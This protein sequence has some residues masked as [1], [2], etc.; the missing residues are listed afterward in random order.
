MKILSACYD[1]YAN[2]AYA[3]CEALKSVGVDCTGAKLIKH[4]FGYAEELPVVGLD[5]MTELIRAADLVQIMHSDITVLKI[6]KQLNKKSVVYHT[7][8]IYRSRQDYMKQLF[9]PFVLMSF[10]DQCEFIGTGMKNECYIATAVDTDKIKFVDKEIKLPY[11][12]AHY[13]SNAEVKGTAKIKE[14]MSKISSDR[15]QFLCSSSTI[16]E[17]GETVYEH[18]S[19]EENLKRMAECDIYIELF[20]PELHGKPYGCWGVTAFEAAA[21]G[22]VVITNNIHLKAYT[23]IYNTPRLFIVNTEIGFTNIIDALVTCKES[24][25]ISHSLLV[26]EWIEA[27][28]SYQSTGN[29]LKQIIEKL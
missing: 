19:H 17:K 26:R 13:P 20:K 22:K 8:S 12:V 24:E 7:G 16:N 21:M 10:T 29:R 3:N 15:F 23:D 4:P 27:N 14:M 25:L 2:F 9:N 5:E 11:I 6:C 28:H 1:D 18:V